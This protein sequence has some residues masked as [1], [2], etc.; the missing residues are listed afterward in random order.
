MEGKDINL[1]KYLRRGV[2]LGK[3][4]VLCDK[5]MLQEKLNK[6]YCRILNAFRS[7]KSFLLFCFLSAT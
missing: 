1:P 4:N 6:T 5:Y 7:I 3:P 2:K